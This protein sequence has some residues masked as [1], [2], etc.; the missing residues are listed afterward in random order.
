MR[1]REFIALAACAA[2]DVALAR[3]HTVAAELA[4]NAPRI[5]V[6]LPGSARTAAL[7]PR[8]QAFYQALRDFGWIEGQNIAFEGRYA[9]GQ[10]E[11]LGALAGEL[12]RLNV[13]VIVTASNPPAVA[14]KA[15]T[16]TVPIVIMDP[17]DPVATGLVASLAHP[18]GNVTGVSSVAPD[19]AAKR[20]QTLKEA[21]PSVSR[22]SVLFNAAIPPAEVAMKEMTAAAQILDIQVHSV[23]VL[24]PNGFDEAFG[25]ITRASVDGLVVFADPL[26]HSHQDEIVNFTIKNRIAALF[27]GREF[28]DI[29]GLISYGPSYPGM[30]HRGA[31]YVDRILKG[32]KP[33]DLPV[34]QPAKFELVI[35]LKTAKALGLTLPT[36]LLARAD[37]V[38]E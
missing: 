29:G 26:T 32:T 11:R 38:I 18:G 3:P 25:L 16:D 22:V 10:L 15:A 27:A 36:S 35:N 8:M 7:D 37:E 5:G 19:L 23:A 21:V 34:E 20:L 14:A 30:F 6:L 12:A 28:V 24:G 13:N 31:Y 17:G 1:R 33:A 9:E 2:A 4:M